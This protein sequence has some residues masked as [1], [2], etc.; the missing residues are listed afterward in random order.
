MRYNE[1]GSSG[2]GR[3]QLA[4]D[5]LRQRQEVTGSIPVGSIS[6]L[7]SNSL[8]FGRWHDRLGGLIHEYTIAA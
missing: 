1:V 4:G 3:H 5:S 8:V 7:P 2:N 6:K